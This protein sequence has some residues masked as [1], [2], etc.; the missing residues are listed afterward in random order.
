MK[1]SCE[2]FT[3]IFRGE[4]S[5][6]VTLRIEQVNE[7]NSDPS[8]RIVCD[9][10]AERQPN[11]TVRSMFES[12]S[13]REVPKGVNPRALPPGTLDENGKIRSLGHIVNH[14]PGPFEEFWSDMLSSMRD[15]AAQ[16]I[17]ALRWRLNRPQGANPVSQNPFFTAF[18]LDDETWHDMPTMG[19]GLLVHDQDL[20][21]FTPALAADVRQALESQSQ[22]PIAHELFREAWAVR[23]GNLK[24]SLLI[25]YSAAEVG[26]KQ[27]IGLVL[28]YA[29]C[30]MANIQ[31]PPLPK[32]LNYLEQIPNKASQQGPTSQLPKTV[33]TQL[34]WIP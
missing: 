26:I 14:M 23:F 4:T 8:D 29:E 15:R 18:S 19:H 9:V 17:S 21:T 11:E 31:S 24:S 6:K 7:Q 5:V 33:K 10:L 16:V 1:M 22:E 32:L 13:R 3:C 34:A 28:P 12:L 30:L 25:G 2:D 20:I 27:H